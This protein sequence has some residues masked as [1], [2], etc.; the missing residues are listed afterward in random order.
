VD[1]PGPLLLVPGDPNRSMILYR[2]SKPGLDRKQHV[3]SNVV[4]EKAGGCRE[5]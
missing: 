2:T 3:A 5:E 4:D 1:L